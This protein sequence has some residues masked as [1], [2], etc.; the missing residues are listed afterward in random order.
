MD[1]WVKMRREEFDK[2]EI[3]R[4]FVEGEISRAEAAKKLGL[5]ER[6]VTNRANKVRKSGINGAYH[7]NRGKTPKVKKSEHTRHRYIAKRKQIYFDFNVKHAWEMIAEGLGS[8]KAE[9]V[10]YSTFYNWCRDQSLLK[11]KQRRRTKGRKLR[12][13]MPCEGQMLQFDGSPHRW[14][15]DE[16]ST[17]IQAIDD[18]SSDL[19]AGEFF[20]SE[21]TIACMKVLRR[22]IETRGIPESLYIDKAGWGGGQKRC[23]FS[24]FEE[25]CKALNIRLI[26]ANSPEAKGRVE[27][28][29]RTH[30]DRLPPLLRHNGISNKADATRYFNGCYAREWRS[31][32]NVTPTSSETRYGPAPSA[33][34][35]NEIMSIKEHR[36]ARRDGAISYCNVIYKV[37]TKHGFPPHHGTPVEIRHYLDGTW[38]AFV[39]QERSTLQIAPK[40]RQPNHRYLEQ[41]QRGNKEIDEQLLILRKQLQPKLA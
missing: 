32:Y 35:L 3:I 41:I 27:R 33:S 1:G 37:T 10:S 4:T 29:N 38:S 16:E 25:A 19:V 12:D 21:T 17:L 15:G 7:G 18:A 2:Y 39:N 5:T 11:H 9:P 40:N 20:E 24:H 26:Y 14:F 30:Q 28:S 23:N 31:K 13:R 34:E 8:S 22:I 36:E 6:A